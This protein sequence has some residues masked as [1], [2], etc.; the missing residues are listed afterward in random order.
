M[1]GETRIVYFARAPIASA[2]DQFGRRSDRLQ[3]EFKRR[4]V[5]FARRRANAKRPGKII[6]D[7]G[8]NA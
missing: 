6:H 8:A 7:A 2:A 4:V 5:V 1:N 3:L